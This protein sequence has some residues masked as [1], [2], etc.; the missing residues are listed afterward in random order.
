[1]NNPE[2]V[3]VDEGEEEESLNEMFGANK[4]VRRAKQRGHKKRRVRYHFTRSEE[5]ALFGTVLASKTN[6][7]RSFDRRSHTPTCE[8]T[9]S[10]RIASYESIATPTTK[11]NRTDNLQRRVISIRSIRKC[12]IARSDPLD[13]SWV[14]GGRQ[15]AFFVFPHRHVQH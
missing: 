2:G 5:I 15:R 8:S 7:A 9:L 3:V 6:N 1:M 12:N 4:R 11:Y 13:R 14:R 10:A